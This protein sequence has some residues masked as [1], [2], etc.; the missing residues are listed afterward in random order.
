M[1]WCCDGAHPSII[2]YSTKGLHI[3]VRI[4]V[5]IFFALIFNFNC[6]AFIYIF[7]ILFFMELYHSCP[8][9]VP[10]ESFSLVIGDYARP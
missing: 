7:N 9:D 4:L 5:N 3:T 8:Q 6:F 10:I 1:D 2:F